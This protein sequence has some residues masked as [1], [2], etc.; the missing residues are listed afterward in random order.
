MRR[1]DRTVDVGALQVNLQSSKLIVISN[2]HNEKRTSYAES[3]L[4]P[5][6][7]PNAHPTHPSMHDP[8]QSS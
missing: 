3:P 2:S 7:S 4:M 5:L 8:I 1:T 6:K